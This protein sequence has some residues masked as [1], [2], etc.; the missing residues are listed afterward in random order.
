MDPMK[1][2]LNLPGWARLTIALSVAGAMFALIWW[3]A[4]QEDAREDTFMEV[5]WDGDGVAHYPETKEQKD[6]CPGGVELLQW[7]KNLKGVYLSDYGMLEESHREAMK[8]VNN[9]LGFQALIH[10]ESPDADIVIRRGDLNEGEGA[11]STSHKMVDGV[12]QATITVRSTVDSREWMLEEQHELL[13]AL[14]LAH[15]RS[16]IMSKSLDEPTGMKVWLLHNKDREALR[17][18]LLTPPSELDRAQ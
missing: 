14:G 18:L 8:W 16:G 10:S 6:A 2:F 7:R 15:D 12:I 4:K 17:E 3:M 9:E 11:M 13:H 1:G 5:C